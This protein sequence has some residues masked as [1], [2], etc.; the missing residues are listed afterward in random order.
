MKGSAQAWIIFLIALFCIILVYNVFTVVMA[1]TAATVTGILNDTTPVAGFNS[2]ATLTN[3]GTVW[4]YFPILLILGLIIW[5]FIASS[6]AEP[7]Y[8]S[9]Y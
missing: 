4:N 3:I 7:V 2:T 5:V 6:R 9:G 8:E 1:P